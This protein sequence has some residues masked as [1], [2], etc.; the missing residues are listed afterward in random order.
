MENSIEV[1]YKSKNRVTIDSAILLLSIYPQ[2]S[3]KR[4]M[5]LNVH[6]STVYNGQDM[7]A[8]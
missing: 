6:S 5:N 8:T 7:E 1:P 2:N 4:Y 3:S